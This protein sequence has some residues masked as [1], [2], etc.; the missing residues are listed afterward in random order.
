MKSMH[1]PKGELIPSATNRAPQISP[2]PDCS[3]M[4]QA[5]V[6][7]PQT[8]PTDMSMPPPIMTMHIPTVAIKRLTFRLKKSRRSET[9]GN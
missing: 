8:A 6:T 4:A 3:N 9:A 5:M 2:V 1:E 7:E